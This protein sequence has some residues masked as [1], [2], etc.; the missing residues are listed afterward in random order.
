MRITL[1]ILLIF[2]FLFLSCEKGEEDQ[3]RQNEIARVK[4][5]ILNSEIDFSMKL[6][7][8]VLLDQGDKNLAVS[9][10][11]AFMALS[12]A[13]NGADEETLGEMLEVLGIE[14][15]RVIVLNEAIN[16]INESLLYSDP[17]TRFESANS[18]WYNDK[19]RIF[20]DYQ[21]TV[22]NYY[23]ADSK[24]IDFS[25]PGSVDIINGWVEDETEGKITDLI[26]T[27]SPRDICYIVNALYFNG[28]WTE[29]FDPEK[30]KLRSFFTSKTEKVMVP[31][32]EIG[33]EYNVY[34]EV[35]ISG[36]E[37]PYGNKNWSM[38]VF[39]APYK[40]PF[41][42]GELFRETIMNNFD[43][44]LEKFEE[45]STVVRF[46]QFSI[47]SEF[48]MV[49]YLEAM[50]IEKAFD[51][52]SADFSKLTKE[53][54]WIGK[55]KQKAYLRVNENGTEAAAATAVVMVGAGTSQTIHFNRP[56]IYFIREKTTG[57]IIFVGQVINPNDKV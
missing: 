31:M 32:M 10:Y 45:A 44:T 13:A 23:E 33:G 46:P 43:E 53:E 20:E 19:V 42:T 22:F 17:D 28:I 27:V 41:D 8:Q 25:D 11:S 16:A 52:A 6:F 57:S 24:G 40:N 2:P 56:F 48:E 36:I 39:L 26:A 1:L 9:P 38:Y 15:K 14:G 4:S 49:K 51:A 5:K 29:T 12:M 7:E 18:V 54:C 50:G 21:Q 30:T 55:V 37:L 47:K 35:G 34:H 3:P